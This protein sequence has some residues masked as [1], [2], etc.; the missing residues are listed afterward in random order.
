MK[1]ICIQP[2]SGLEIFDKYNS[3]INKKDSTDSIDTLDMELNQLSFKES[4]GT[5]D[6]VDSVDSIDTLDTKLNQL[7]FKEVKDKTIPLSI[8]QSTDRI[9]VLSESYFESYIVAIQIG[10][11]ST[12]QFF[13]S[14]ALSHNPK[15][16]ILQ[17]NVKSFTTWLLE[18]YRHIFNQNSNILGNMDR[19]IAQVTGRLTASKPQTS[20]CRFSPE[21]KRKRSELRA[22]LLNPIT[23]KELSMDKTLRS[24]RTG[25]RSAQRHPL[26]VTWHITDDYITPKWG[27]GD[28][29]RSR[30]RSRNNK[31]LK[32]T[33]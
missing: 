1:S 2:Y 4:D 11:H 25:K 6:S 15:N 17:D 16:T 9:N 31:T 26:I 24:K 18:E 28:N 29:T 23:D 21:E 3:N 14:K 22:S 8:S 7:S 5:E 33:D 10:D 20:L 12:A 32:V 30:W 13:I 27:G 19:V